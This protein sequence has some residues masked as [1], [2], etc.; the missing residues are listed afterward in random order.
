MGT[1][2]RGLSRV[3]LV[4]AGG[5]AWGLGIALRRAG[6]DIDWVYSRSGEHSKA[7]AD[8]LECSSFSGASYPQKPTELLI[9]AVPDTEC[10]GVCARFANLARYVV[11]TSGATPIP[12]IPGARVGVFYPLQTFA[13][14]AETSLQRV[15]C[16]IEAYDMELREAI[17]ELAQRIGMFVCQANS[18]ER[19]WVHLLGVLSNNFVN[20]LLHIATTIGMCRGIDVGSQLELPAGEADFVRR[21]LEPILQQTIGNAVGV[22]PTQAQTGP[23]RRGDVATLSRHRAMLE[24]YYPQFLPLYNALTESIERS[25]KGEVESD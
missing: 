21:L 9:V 12:Q 18:E 8:A 11:H 16:L 25:C 13:R 4:G 10:L 22:G 17:M 20:H 24:T 5:V 14:G 19:R 7:L 2:G 6:V 1:T 3:A 23:A 15:P